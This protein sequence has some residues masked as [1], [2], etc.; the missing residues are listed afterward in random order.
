[1]SSYFVIIRSKAQLMNFIDVMNSYGYY[2]TV[3][4]LPKEAKL[5]CGLSGAI[6]GQDVAKAYKIISYYKYDSY[7]GIFSF[8]KY[9][10]KLVRV[11]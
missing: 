2:A 1:M 7:Y 4:S 5:G 8:D 6:N 9:R 11:Y 10:K 3:T